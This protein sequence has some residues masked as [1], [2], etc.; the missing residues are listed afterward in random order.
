MAEHLSMKAL[1][2]VLEALVRERRT[3]TLYINCDDRHVV[4]FALDNGR[5]AAVYHGP[6]RGRKALESIGQLTGGGTHHFEQVDTMTLSSQD[7]PA[8]RELIEQLRAAMSGEGGGPAVAPAASG[9]PG[10]ASSAQIDRFKSELRQL[11]TTYVGPIAGMV[12]D[13]CCRE[14]D[15]S[16]SNVTQARSIIGKLSQEISDKGEARRFEQEAAMLAKRLLAG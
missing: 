3:G 16:G 9:E 11:L 14:A 2:N 6:K 8:T 12:V 7:I 1:V 15:Q 5:I 13:D 4:T 10:S